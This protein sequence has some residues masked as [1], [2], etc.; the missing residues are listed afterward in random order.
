MSEG[1]KIEK[2]EERRKKKK[3]NEKIWKENRKNAR[4]EL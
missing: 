2:R 1:K 4:E 3:A